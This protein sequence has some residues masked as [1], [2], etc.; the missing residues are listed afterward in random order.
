MLVINMSISQPDDRP[1]SKLQKPMFL[2]LNSIAMPDVRAVSTVRV[3]STH[4]IFQ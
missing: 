2:K 1:T 3:S 4:D